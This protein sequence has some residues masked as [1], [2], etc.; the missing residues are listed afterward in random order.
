MKGRRAKAC[1]PFAF[2]DPV[3][4]MD[5]MAGDDIDEIGD[6]RD[7]PRMTVPIDPF[8]PDES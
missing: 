5:D 7:I 4:D 1:R 6:S 3:R 2:A 8:R